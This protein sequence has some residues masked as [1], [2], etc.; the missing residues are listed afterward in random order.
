MYKSQVLKPL[1]AADLEAFRQKLAEPRPQAADPGASTSTYR[2]PATCNVLIA[3]TEGTFAEYVS[4]FIAENRA[5]GRVQRYN[6][7][8][9]DGLAEVVQRLVE[10]N[11][12]GKPYDAVVIPHDAFLSEGTAGEGITVSGLELVM[13][14]KGYRTAQKDYVRK[15]GIIKKHIPTRHN[16]DMERDIEFAGLR[17]GYSGV[18][19]ILLYLAQSDQRIRQLMAQQAKHASE[20]RLQTIRTFETAS[21]NQERLLEMLMEVIKE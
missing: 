9:A 4:G 8:R 18:P 2:V 13:S 19:F 11:S 3:S 12:E 6:I 20:A 16:T 10:A 17:S 7:I 1:S 5:R 15:K 21:K 14:I